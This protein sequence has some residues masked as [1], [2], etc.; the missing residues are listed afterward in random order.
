VK[1]PVLALFFALLPVLFSL[2]VFASGDIQCIFY[3]G[4]SCPA[5]TVKFLGLEN[6]SDGYTNAHA[7]NRTIGTYAY[8]FCC[9][10]TNASITHS[11]GCDGA[12]FLKLSDEDNAHVQTGNN[13]DYP[14]LACI[15]STYQNVTCS[16]P[17]NSCGA[18]SACMLSI[19]NSEGAND[20]NSHIGNCSDYTKKVCC[21]SS[22]FAPT[23]PVLVYPV[24][25]NASVEE[26]FVN[27]S[28][29]ASAD[30]EDN[31]V[32]YTINATCGASCACGS[33]S[34]SLSGLNYTHT[35]ELCVG[36]QYNWTVTACDNY[37]ACA[38]SAEWNFTIADNADFMLIV[39]T[40]DFGGMTLG[41]S[42]QTGDS[43][44]ALVGRN[45]GNVKL[46]ATINASALFTSGSYPS[47][48]YLYQVADNETGSIVSGCSQVS[49]AQI[50]SVHGLLFCNLTWQDAADE[51]KIDINVTVPMV[52]SPGEKTSTIIVWYETAEPAI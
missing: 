46:N 14:I 24:N 35:S 26:R 3:S 1:Q 34:T 15:N 11:T 13:T 8:S 44:Q 31:P 48:D 22:N 51:V 33:F 27:F 23:A 29:Q 6:D 50:N 17:D 37:D 40:T 28:W 18:G 38:I 45:I 36:Y 25:N 19:A 2:A 32:T 41:E 12:T 10:S 20:T 43:L 30:P 4:A 47:S 5:G 16:F 9:N 7:Q 42:K 21:G 52:E 49:L 39:N